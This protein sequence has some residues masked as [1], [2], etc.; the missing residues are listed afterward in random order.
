MY[1]DEFWFTREKMK[2]GER[3][4]GGGGRRSGD[5]RREE[6]DHLIACLLP[7]PAFPVLRFLL[8]SLGLTQ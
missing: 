3:L 8:A 5:S 1:E 4:G 2:A 7:D 6:D